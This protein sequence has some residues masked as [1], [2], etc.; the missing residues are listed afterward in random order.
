MEGGRGEE[1]VGSEPNQTLPSASQ[2][3]EELRMGHA[4]RQQARY[5]R[6]LQR[7]RRHESRQRSLREAREELQ[8]LREMS[9]RSIASA[10]RVGE[11]RPFAMTQAD[12]AGTPEF[13]ARQAALASAYVT[14]PG[15]IASPPRARTRVG[16]AAPSRATNAATVAAAAAAAARTE[17]RGIV[18][19][20]DLV[21]TGGTGIITPQIANTMAT[22]AAAVSASSSS[23]PHESPDRASTMIHAGNARAGP[24]SSISRTMS[25]EDGVED[26]SEC[27]RNVQ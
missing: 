15:A 13:A 19:V 9:P 17:S 18:G 2:T 26:P 23:A 24:A 27:S 12:Q 16:G 10:L 7:M 8:Q 20:R 3:T 25:N 5:Q 11:R 22:S 4:R 1:G 14:M 6:T 21:N